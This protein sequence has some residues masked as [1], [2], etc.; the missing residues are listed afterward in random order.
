VVQLR[1]P[2][3]VLTVIG[4]TGIVYGVATGQMSDVSVHASRLC[5]DCIGLGGG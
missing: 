1:W 3:L 4:I 5:L 2:W